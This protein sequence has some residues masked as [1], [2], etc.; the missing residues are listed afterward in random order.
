MKTRLFYLVCLIAVFG[1]SAC[2]QPA[3]EKPYGN[4][5]AEGFNA[6]GSDAKAIAIADE[7][8]EAMG[9]RKAWDE[10][11]YVCWTFFGRDEL[12][13]DKWTGNVR[14]DRGNGMTLLSNV[15]DGTGRAFI[16]GREITDTDSLSNLMSAAKRTWINHSYWLVMPYKL[17]DSG[18]TLKYMDTDTTQNGREADKLMLTFEAVGVTPQNKYEIWVD[19]ESRLM[20]QW[21][22]YQTVDAEAP[23]FVNPWLEYNK[24]GKIMLS[25]VREGLGNMEDIM[26]FDELPE[27]VFTSPEKIDLKT[28]VQ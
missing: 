18:V 8:M 2:N 17:K 23:R 24:H 20:S 28:L 5:A 19:K 6:A 25:K 22:F 26:V 15:N 3:K 9:G 1:L 27:A 4:P 14:I 11:H 7:V 10:T 12:V 21:A 13:W 16:S